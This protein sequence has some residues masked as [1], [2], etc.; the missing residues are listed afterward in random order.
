MK[1]AIAVSVLAIMSLSCG[2]SKHDKSAR[3]KESSIIIDVRTAKE[4]N[5]GHLKN[6][7]NIP[8]TEI[9]ERIAGHAKDK[10]GKITVYCRSGHRS[11]IAKVTLEK[12]GYTSVVNAGAYEKL[13]AQEMKNEEE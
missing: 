1:R 11:G 4:Y 13:K 5:K 6:A 2:L 3:V 12:L 8:H 9:G 10:E 7:I